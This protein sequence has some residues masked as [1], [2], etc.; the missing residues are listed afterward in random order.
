MPHLSSSV[1]IPCFLYADVAFTIFAIYLLG[2]IIH[3]LV[4]TYLHGAD[5][6]KSHFFVQ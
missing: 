3:I 6:S 4:A 1:N 2:L 5:L